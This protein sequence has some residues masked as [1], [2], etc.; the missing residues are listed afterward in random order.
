MKRKELIRIK[1]MLQRDNYNVTDNFTKLLIADLTRV[2]SE[3]F[4][5]SIEPSFEFVKKGEL[6]FINSIVKIDNVKRFESLVNN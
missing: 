2:L 3:Y 4:D 5:Y 1:N 6:V